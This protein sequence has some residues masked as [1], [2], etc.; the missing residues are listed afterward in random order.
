MFKNLTSFPNAEENNFENS[1]LNLASNLSCSTELEADI[2]HEEEKIVRRSKR[3]TK[4]NPIIRYNNP[5]CH[6]Y[7]RHRRKVELGSDAG[8]NGFGDEQPQLIQTTDNNST[9]RT[10]ITVTTINARIGYPST[11]QWTIGGI[12]AIQKLNRSPLAEQQPILRGG[13]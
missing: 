10:N 8:S 6:D 12:N 1:E 5:I 9:S 3:L 13:T 11:N 7:R 2:Q 4:T